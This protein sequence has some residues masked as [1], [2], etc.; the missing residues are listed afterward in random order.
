MPVGHR[1]D[2]VGDLGQRLAIQIFG[3]DCHATALVII[4][5]QSTITGLLP[6]LSIP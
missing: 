4:E 2:Q 6:Q 1:C 5:V 3:A